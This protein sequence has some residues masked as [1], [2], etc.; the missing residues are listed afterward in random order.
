[1]AGACYVPFSGCIPQKVLWATKYQDSIIFFFACQLIPPPHSLRAP[2]DEPAANNTQ[3]SI[4]Q[5]SYTISNWASYPSDKSPCSET[6]R[7][8][9]SES[10]HASSQR[11]SQGTPNSNLS[12]RHA[13]RLALE[14]SSLTVGCR[15]SLDTKAALGLCISVMTVSLLPSWRDFTAYAFIF[16]TDIHY[17]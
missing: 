11:N 3:S 16:Q 5:R 4:I 8:A 12:F 2:L 15:G 13:G 9:Y 17:R 14:S 1:M 7:Y 10:R 6:R